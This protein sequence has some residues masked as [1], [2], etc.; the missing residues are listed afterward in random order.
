MYERWLVRSAI[1][2]K[3]IARLLLLGRARG[4]L[5]TT[6]GQSDTRKGESAEHNR[7]SLKDKEGLE[8]KT[9]GETL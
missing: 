1:Q 8:Y 2:T 6:Q 3:R 7:T 5:P 4:R 9:A